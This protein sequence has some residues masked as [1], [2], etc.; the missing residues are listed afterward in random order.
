MIDPSRPG[1]ERYRPIDDVIM[2]DIGG[3]VF[4]VPIRGQL[5]DLQELFVLDEVGSWLWQRFGAEAG[6][7]ELAELVV[8]E[9]ETTIDRARA[10]VAIFLDELLAAG[11]VEPV[12]SQAG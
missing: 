7:D 2:R 12:S 8:T 1:A 3:E 5:A 11:L 4:L 6:V 9:F 10:D